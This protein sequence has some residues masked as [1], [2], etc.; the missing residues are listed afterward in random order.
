MMALSRFKAVIF[1]L[2]N[3]AFCGTA[4]GQGE[5]YLDNYKELRIT[6]YA[7]PVIPHDVD[8]T[9]CLDC[10]AMNDAGVPII[11]HR[12]LPN[13][14]QCHVPQKDVP[15][16]KKNEFQGTK[17][18]EKLPRMHPSAPPVLPHKVFMH[19]NCLACHGKDSKSGVVKTQ[20]QERLNCLQCHVEQKSDVTLFRKN[21]NIKDIITK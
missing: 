19:E 6:A 20:H 2:T 3:I 13:C 1:F 9:P 11:P 16:F 21:T 14:R 4:L 5:T 18:I 17:R 7:P 10:H 8:D 15:L 12:E